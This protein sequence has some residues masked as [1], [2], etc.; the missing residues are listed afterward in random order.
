MGLP[1]GSQVLASRVDTG[2]RGRPPKEKKGGAGG[3]GPRAET[4]GRGQDDARGVKRKRTGAADGETEMETADTAATPKTPKTITSTARQPAEVSP[5]SPHHSNHTPPTQTIQAASGFCHVLPP[6]PEAWTMSL[7]HRTQVVY[8]PDYSYVIQKMSVRPGSVVLE[9][10]AGSG[11]FTHAAARA[12]FNGYAGDEQDGGKKTKRRGHVYSFEYHEPRAKQLQEEIKSHGLGGVVTV[13]HRDVYAD[14]FC[15]TSKTS[16]QPFSELT[17]SAEHS[18]KENGQTTDVDP[19]PALTSTPQHRSPNATHIFLDLP[20]PW[21]C[22]PHFSRTLPTTNP[23]HPHPPSPLNPNAPIHLASFLP[24]HEQC[25]R[26]LSSLCAHNWTEISMST[27]E[28]RRLEVRRER[29]GYRYE[30]QRGVCAF[31][32]SVGEAVERLGALEREWRREGRGRGVGV[33]V[34]HVDANRGDGDADDGGK[35]GDEELGMEEGGNAGRGKNEKKPKE[36]KES[37]QERIAR[38]AAETRSRK[39]WAEGRLTTRTEPELKTHTGYLVMAVLP[40]S[41]E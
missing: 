36:K 3:R 7:P 13:T 38:L 39:P 40:V 8:T 21:R 16:D 24:C 35:D 29:V 23:S 31:A 28:H 6:T 22:L 10:G 34:E 18:T 5:A 19:V 20:A 17:F 30:G 37:K 33:D 15:L 25:T 4:N 14:G 2:S 26:L 11:S 9:A 41:F 32:G 12:V 27:L 1:W